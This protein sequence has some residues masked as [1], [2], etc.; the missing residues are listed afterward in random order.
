MKWF[1]PKGTKI[2]TIK[3]GSNYAEVRFD[4]IITYEI[5]RCKGPLTTQIV[6][7]SDLP[8]EILDLIIKKMDPKFDLS[9]F[10]K[11]KWLRSYINTRVK[12]I[13]DIDLLRKVEQ[14]LGEALGE[15]YFGE[16]KI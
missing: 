13:D 3:K 10:T 1:I 2:L 15:K 12:L 16:H 6:A 5:N 8:E 9:K 11:I 7:V 14:I 4:K